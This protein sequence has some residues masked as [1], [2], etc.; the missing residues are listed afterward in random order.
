MKKLFLSIALLSVAGAQAV[1]GTDIKFKKRVESHPIVLGPEIVHGSLV[2]VSPTQHLED[3]LHEWVAKQQS[4]VNAMEKSRDAKG[5]ARM[6]SDLLRFLEVN[7]VNSLNE[8]RNVIMQVQGK[9]VITDHLSKSP[10][11]D[12]I[13]KAK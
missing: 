5:L 1:S 10:M 4:A 13:M 11:R 7:G 3:E 12:R 6:T 2:Q 8:Y 9:A